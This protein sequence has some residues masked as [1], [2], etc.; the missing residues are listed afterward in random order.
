MLELVGWIAVNISVTLASGDGSNEWEL[1]LEAVEDSKWIRCA[2]L[3]GC[4]IVIPRS[5]KRSALR[6]QG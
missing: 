5:D 4:Q 6:T 3:A 1:E 2:H